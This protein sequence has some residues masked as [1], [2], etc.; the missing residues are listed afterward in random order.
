MYPKRSVAFYLRYPTWASFSFALSWLH[1]PK[2]A[3]NSDFWLAIMRV[4]FNPMYSN[5][6]M[7][8]ALFKLV[9]EHWEARSNIIM[10]E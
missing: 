7:R 3:E 4:S 2:E 6:Y 10:F 9:I 1:I 8:A 5:T